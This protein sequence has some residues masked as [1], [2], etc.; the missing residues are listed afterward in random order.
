[1]KQNLNIRLAAKDDLPAIMD[2]FNQAIRS[3]NACGFLEETDIEERQAWFAN[4]SK[5][6]HPVYTAELNGKVVGYGS[7]SPYRPGRSA[8]RKVAEVSFFLDFNFHN[9]GVGTA[10]LSHMIRDC[11]RLEIESLIAILLGS[12]YASIAL[13]R[14]HGFGEWGR[15]PGIIDFKDRICDHLY[16][17]LKIKPVL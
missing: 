3:R 16:Y 12:N 9:K 6:S 10:L 14:K 5:N 17:G 2:I 11:P 15:M 7:L 1:M 4:H 13:L 8:M